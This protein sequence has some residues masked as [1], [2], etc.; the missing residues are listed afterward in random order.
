MTVRVVVRS[1]GN[2]QV[3]TWDQTQDLEFFSSN[4]NFCGFIGLVILTLLLKLVSQNFS[5]PRCCYLGPPF[6]AEW[7][8][9]NIL[10]DQIYQYFPPWQK[11]I[12]KKPD[13]IWLWLHVIILAVTV[14]LEGPSPNMPV[15][16]AFSLVE[17]EQTRLPIGRDPVA[18]P[19]LA[20][21]SAACS[22]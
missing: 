16:L 1:A 22:G 15:S 17:T 4:L 5:Y 11:E 20:A 6:T 18:S 2:N 21:A 19:A 12:R 3:R 10:T 8:P 14:T 7:I 9:A 13:F